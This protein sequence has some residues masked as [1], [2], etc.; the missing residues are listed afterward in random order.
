MYRV[1]SGIC[2]LIL[3]I[4][5]Y[6]RNPLVYAL[7]IG[8]TKGVFQILRIREITYVGIMSAILMVVGY[9]IIAIVIG[10]FIKERSPR[11]NYILDYI[12][13]LETLAFMFYVFGVPYLLSMFN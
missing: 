3:I 11:L 5:S 4:L 6:K 7:S 13:G 10:Y 8:T 12:L 9:S 2:V 1:A